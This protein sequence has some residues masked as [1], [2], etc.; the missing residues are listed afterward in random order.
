MRIDKINNTGFKAGLTSQIMEIEKHTNPAKV[1]EYFKASPYTDW[2]D[3]RYNLDF[4]DNKAFALACRMCA[5]IF[6][7]FREKHDYRFGFSNL[8]LIFPRGIYAFNPWELD[9]N[10]KDLSKKCFTTI[11][12][13][14]GLLKTGQHVGAHTIF[15]NNREFIT[16]L[17]Q[18]NYMHYRSHSSQ[19]FL[20][21][22]IHEW[23]HAIQSK[24]I[25]D[26]A[27]CYGYDYKESINYTSNRQVSDKENEIVF[28]VLGAYAAK[29][30]ENGWQYP[31]IF[32]E[33]WTKF[34]CDSLD[35]DCM[36][37]K[38]DP[39]DELKKTPKEFREILKKVSK[40][41]ML[42]DVNDPH[43]GVAYSWN[44]KLMEG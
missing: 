5:N 12:V 8:N 22:F 16:S 18:A 13:D 11:D 4:K 35:D 41:G 10:R 37:F 23:I 15:L 3:F 33:A 43:V 2:L 14:D 25:H 27:K 38:K 20:H 24:L 42:N 19:H 36:N 17:E 26:C 29:R 30:Q 1:Q 39:I 31:E 6:K 9:D 7:K 28:D 21:V 44:S 40:V 34:I 32:A